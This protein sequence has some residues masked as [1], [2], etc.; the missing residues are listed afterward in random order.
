MMEAFGKTQT[1]LR[2][3][4]KF[5]RHEG[6]D[7]EFIQKIAKAEYKY[8]NAIRNDK[9]LCTLVQNMTQEILDIF[10]ALIEWR[11]MFANIIDENPRKI[12]SA[13]TLLHLASSKEGDCNIDVIKKLT[14]PTST[15]VYKSPEEPRQFNVIRKIIQT[16]GS[17]IQNLKSL[18]CFNCLQIG[19]GPAWAC[20]FPKSRRNYQVWI[21]H[22]ENRNHKHKQNQRR[23]FNLAEKWG[24]RTAK[25]IMTK[26]EGYNRPRR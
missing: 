16:R 18:K 3:L 26:K 13:K 10:I 25:A 7:D 6:F 24:E 22:E 2:V 4:Y 15:Y 19:H 14:G 8:L 9:S 1:L 20:P 21:N 17:Y 23:F 12:I 5:R 11:E